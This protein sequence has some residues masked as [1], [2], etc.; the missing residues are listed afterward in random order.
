MAGIWEGVR[1]RE[2][3][4]VGD[5]SVKRDGVTGRTRQARE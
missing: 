1:S 5:S 2:Y 4:T 3:I